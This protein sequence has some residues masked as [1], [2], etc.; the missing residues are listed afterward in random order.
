[1]DIF[2]EQQD[3]K[4]A[5]CGYIYEATDDKKIQGDEE[6]IR[7]FTAHKLEIKNPEPMSHG[8]YNHNDYLQVYIYGCPKCK[9]IIFD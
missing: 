5:A 6:F 7:I 9:T 8:D 4:C 1:M 3:L 2:L